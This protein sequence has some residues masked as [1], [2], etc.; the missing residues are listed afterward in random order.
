M[1]FARLNHILIPGT[2]DERERWRRGWV[3]R[4]V[5]PG[6][7]LFNA[8]SEEGRVLAVLTL[9]VG[10]AGLGVDSTRVYVLWASLSGLLLG[11]LLVRRAY[12][13]S[14]IRMEVTAPPRV[15]AG[16]ALSF[17][18]TL[19]N[20]GPRDRHAIRI[21]GPFLPWDGSWVDEMPRLPHLE[22]GGVAQLEVRGRFVQ[23]GRHHLDP[24][25]ASALVPFG[26]T[27]GPRVGTGGCRFVVVPRIAR[28]VE[29]ELPMGGSYQHG[30]VAN[31][32]LTG[33]A[34]ELLGVRPYR[35]GDALRDLHAKT[36]AR[37]GYPHV[38]EYQQEYFTRIGII[39]DNDEERSTEEGLE[40][41]IS[42]AAGVVARLTRGEAL[43]D[44]M[45]VGREVHPFTLGRALGTLDQAL[46]LLACVEPGPTM[47]VTP[48]LERLQP[49]FSRLSCIVVLTQASDASR[50]ELVDA[51]GR[52]G[53]ACRLLR[54][55]EDGGPAW[56][57]RHRNLEPARSLQEVVVPASRIR[58]GEP[59]VL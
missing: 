58:G 21:Q 34:M 25:E 52:R 47:E 2:R 44:L 35:R 55:V 26:L 1:N 36:W 41:L 38:R 46:E 6:W 53:V 9:F 43:I 10:T 57:R 59:L 16:E 40:A 22:A 48:L 45:V 14:R 27:S 8:L 4:V 32:S 11:A 33:E 30:G 17:T 39:V 54:V 18:V 5:A 23:R 7:W 28:V 42:L 15:S 51:I 24:F 50:L 31:A 13:L 37:C 49:Y 12:S 3:G 29:L 20:D 19:R 56:L